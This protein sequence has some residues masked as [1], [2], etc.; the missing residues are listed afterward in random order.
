MRTGLDRDESIRKEVWVYQSCSQPFRIFIFLQFTKIGL[1][2]RKQESE[3]TTVTHFCVLETDMETVKEQE[4][5]EHE[6]DSEEE[7]GEQEETFF[8]IRSNFLK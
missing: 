7:D 2:Q 5:E 3:E 1:L 4:S 8:S 6:D